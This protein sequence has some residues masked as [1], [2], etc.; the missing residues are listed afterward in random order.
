M[1]VRRRSVAGRRRPVRQHRFQEP[2][3]GS[4]PTAGL[5]DANRPADCGRRHSDGETSHHS[6]ANRDKRDRL[7]PAHHSK[8]A[9][10]AQHCRCSPL[11]T[12]A[13][14]IVAVQPG[15]PLLAL[16]PAQLAQVELD[17]G[18]ALFPV[19]EQELLKIAPPRD[20]QRPSLRPGDDHRSGGEQAGT[21]AVIGSAVAGVRPA[22]PHNRR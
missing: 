15:C 17:G 13:G 10:Q 1:D 11:V 8:T 9:P 3:F 2:G 12:A 19:R 20:Q 5:S 21:L 18:P 14:Q 4:Q 7:T 22:R 6:A 16:A